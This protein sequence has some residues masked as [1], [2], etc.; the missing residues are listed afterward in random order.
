M[1]VGE[2]EA[3]L[4]GETEMSQGKVLEAEWGHAWPSKISS[5]AEFQGRQC[6]RHLLGHAGSG[7]TE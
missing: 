6:R 3:Q 5:K 7:S 2:E 1:C 4:E